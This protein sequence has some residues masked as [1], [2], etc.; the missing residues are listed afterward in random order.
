MKPRRQIITKVG[1]AI[2]DFHLIENQDR[3][4]VALSGGKDSWALLY[5]LNAL[6]KKAPVHF[7]LH[8]VTI[9]PGFSGFNP[10]P[11][12][13]HLQ[14]YFPELPYHVE[15]GNI[16]EIIQNHI[17]PGKNVCAFCARLRRGILYR[18]ARDH[19][20]TK[21]ALGH[22]AD[23]LIETLLLNQFFNGRI[24]SM[25]PLLHSDDGQNTIIR[26]LCYVTEK[27]ISEFATAQQFPLLS[28]PCP[29]RKVKNKRA[30]IKKLISRLDSDFPGMR[31]SLLRSMT[32]IDTRH[33][34]D[35]R[36]RTDGTV[37]LK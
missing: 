22:H 5:A 36:Y 32:T 10:A 12:A 3:I 29:N 27:T 23:D 11:L 31:H 9:H 35:H 15:T 14:Q 20:Y 28:P 24:K 4:L 8:P 16:A 17:S 33:L 21:I 30:Q 19:G 13:R 26:P 25:A 1:K 34:M 18:L 6:K 37:D 7:S 2:G